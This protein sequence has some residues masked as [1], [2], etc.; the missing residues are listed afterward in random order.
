MRYVLLE[1]SGACIEAFD[2]RD[3]A[4]EFFL[5]LSEPDPEAAVDFEIV[6]IDDD[7]GECYG[8]I[9]IDR[10]LYLA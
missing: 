9:E 2:C 6:E 4:V 10:D 5:G 1:P 8:S 3:K 7:L